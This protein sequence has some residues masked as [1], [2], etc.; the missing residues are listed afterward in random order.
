MNQTRNQTLVSYGDHAIE[1][2][3]NFANPTEL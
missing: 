2:T 3:N 1:A